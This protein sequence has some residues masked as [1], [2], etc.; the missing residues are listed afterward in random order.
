MLVSTGPGGA[1][2]GEGLLS[3]LDGL[4][5]FRSLADAVRKRL[6]AV[7]VHGLTAGAAPFVLA[8]LF[9]DARRAALWVTHDSTRAERVAA[10]LGVWAPGLRAAVLPAMEVLP[11][12]VV[13]AH[14][15]VGRQRLAVLGRL[16]AG[17]LDVLVAPAAA[18]VKRGVP[19]DLLRGLCLRLDDNA[20]IAPHVVAERLVVLGYE[21]TELVERPGDFAVR[22]GIIDVYPPSDPQPLRI[23]WFGDE[24]DSLRRFDV[25]TQR[26]LARVEYAFVGP[27]RE[28]A[29]TPEARRRAVV[30][31]RGELERVQE[32]LRAADPEAAARLAERVG[33]DL[34]SLETG[35]VFPN[36]SWYVGY[37]Y[38]DASTAADLMPPD[39]ICVIDDWPRI[40]EAL[41]QRQDALHE[42]FSGYLT[43]GYLLPGQGEAYADPGRVESDLRCFPRV[44]LTALPRSLPGVQPRALIGFQSRTVPAFR[45][46]WDLLADEVRAWKG[47][48]R[49]VVIGLPGTERVQRL[50]ELLNQRGA[51]VDALSG[52]V[53]PLPQGRAAAV[54]LPVREGFE[55]DGAA[56]V[57]L[58]DADV[59][60]RPVRRRRRAPV[61]DA[62]RLR[63]YTELVEGDFVVHVNHG[64]GRYLGLRTMEVQGVRR[65][66]L[67]L[68]YQGGDR[69]YVP[70]DQVDLVQKYVGGEGTEPRL[71]RLG[72]AEWSRVK[73]RVRK[74]VRDLAEQLLALYAARSTLRGHAFAPDGPWQREFEDAFPFE[75]T[76]DQLRATEEI[77]RDMEAS[78][79]MDR[80]LC[81][82]VGYGKTEVAM[83]A[84]F[85]AVADGKQVAVLVPTT[86][87][88]QQHYRTFS[89]RFKEFPVTVDV[90][91]RFRTPQQQQRTIA[92][93]REGRVDIVI[94]THRLV[95]RD[96][97]FKDLGLLVIDEEHRFG[98]AQKERI[99]QLKQNVDVLSMTATPIPRTLHMALTG[100]RDL[101]TIETPPEDRH[102]VQTYV[103]EYNPAVIRDAI[104]R[105]LRRGGQV[106][107]VHNR[108]RSIRIIQERL[109]RL[110]PEARIAVAHGQMEEDRLE[111]VMMDFLDGA[112]DILVCTTIVESGLDIAN[113]NT[114][115]V[116]A[117]DTM[118]LAQ[119]YQLRGR[120]GRSHR[121]AYA[122]FTYRR[123]RV[124]TEA[125]EKRLQALKDFTDLGSGFKLALR[126]M[127]I[128]GAGNILGPEQHGFIA[129]VGFD[130]YAQLLE[131]AVQELRG[132]R[133]Q[134]RLRP[135]LDLRWDAFIPDDYIRDARLK[136]DIYKRVDGARTREEL[137]DLRDELIDRFGDPPEP[138]WNLLLAAEVRI[139]AGGLGVVSMVQNGGFL[140]VELVSLP[141]S[142]LERAGLGNR[143]RGRQLTMSGGRPL[144]RI[145]L[146]AGRDGLRAALKELMRDLQ[147]VHRAMAGDGRMK[148]TPPVQY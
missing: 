130:L 121:V 85:K 26:T 143:Q 21:R 142:L 55:L 7:L 140:H 72:G 128:R 105:E 119:L 110:V 39:S 136:V 79:P 81:G 2:T 122:Y 78:R 50:A 74:S 36:M 100:L 62:T 25:A 63:E 34:E 33:H 5:E 12:E 47:G 135:N 46:Q 41:R 90:L 43:A 82:D 54:P 10:E 98:V 68:Q 71:S 56:L 28:P 64:V 146:E 6:D 148:A 117:A 66:Y 52:L 22:G 20:R 141:R 48:R 67:V 15:E 42:Q 123:D 139:T 132:N 120:V 3:L 86:I 133:P 109:R 114:L 40:S 1:R 93:L 129:A 101:S 58:S 49:R 137:A 14:D 13:A 138:V 30:A 102:P 104:Q 51:G 131:E 124:L 107:Y 113:V 94:G 147:R 57:V 31:V 59:A 96:V 84:A 32:R 11:F 17:E 29:L 97:G 19:G 53:E 37:A 70:T 99:K 145:R 116:E 76:E 60:G 24:V 118:G 61:S 89:E 108:V 112:H 27:A 125:A 126:D 38:P 18:L 75:E 45:A 80:L 69:V 77:K 87:L 83:R 92:A 44:Y 95:S 8:R 9:Q 91:S 16:A 106:F 115:I 73:E 111:R 144:I 4:P 103:I 88:A 35:R 134:P 127:E 65:D 23:E